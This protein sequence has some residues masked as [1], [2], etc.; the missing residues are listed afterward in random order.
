M[1]IRALLLTSTLVALSG[2]QA[3]LRPDPLQE[4]TQPKHEAAGRALL[5]K[6]Y[7]AQHGKDSKPWKTQA[8]VEVRLTDT[9]FGF[10]G[11][12]A[13]PWPQNPQDLTIR[14]MP[15]GDR[16]IVDL[17]DEDGTHHRWGVHEWNAWER[18]GTEP[19]EYTQNDDLL[20]WLPTLEY[21]LEAAFRLPEA[22]FVDDAGPAEY[23]GEPHD[24]VYLTWL[25]Y[26]PNDDVDQYLAW[27]RKKDGLLTRLDF[28]VRDVADFVVGTAR[29]SDFRE[30]GGYRLPHTIHIGPEPP[31]DNLHIIKVRRWA[32]NTPLPRAELAPDPKRKPRQ[33]P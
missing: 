23:E 22:Q 24:R 1:K 17:E 20:F 30:V 28:T 13:R 32:P 16:A 7:A 12:V 29:Y 21:F 33:K 31:H 9:F 2:C 14:F 10:T 3:D 6:A 25:T 19:F 4:R 11:W 18:V 8:G 5:Q 26:G 15:A 27:I